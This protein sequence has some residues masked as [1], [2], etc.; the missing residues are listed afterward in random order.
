MNKTK[1]NTKKFLLEIGVEELPARHC[2]SI[3]K[4]LNDDLMKRLPKEHNLDFDNCE[5]LISPRRIVFLADN[6]TQLNQTQD[7]KG[8]IY[9]VAFEGDKP[10]KIA[11]KFAQSHGKTVDD[12][13]I[14]EQNDKRFLFVSKDLSDNFHVQIQNF[15]FEIINQLHFD[16]AMRWDDSKLEFSRPIRWIVCFLENEKIDLKLGNVKSSNI[17]KGNRF[18]Q[19][20]EIDISNSSNYLELI[21]DNF[22]MVDQ[23][24]RR[25]VIQ[26]ALNS[27]KEEGLKKEVSDTIE[28]LVSEVTYLIEWPVPILCQFEEEFLEIPKEIIV[29]VLSKHQKYFHLLNSNDDSLSNKFLVIANHKKASDKIRYGNEKVVKARLSD[30]AFFLEQD[31]DHDFEY[32]RKRSSTITFQEKLGSMLDKS[33]RLRE[34]APKIA[35]TLKSD[36]ESEIIDEAA[37]YSKADLATAMVTEFTSLEGTVGRIYSQKRDFDQKVSVALEEHYLPRNSTDKLP[38]SELGTILSLADKI[39]TLYGMFSLN[40]EPKGNSD[41]YGLRRAA[42]A[43]TKILWEKELEVGI[44]KLIEYPEDLFDQKAEKNTLK[45]FV[46]SRLEQMLQDQQALDDTNLLRAVVYNDSPLFVDKKAIITQLKRRKDSDEFEDLFEM[47]KRVYNIAIKGDKK[48]EEVEI[49]TDSLNKSENAFFEAIAELESQDTITLKDLLA[50][51]EPT[52]EFFENNM[53]MAKDTRKRNTR[54]N[55]LKK[56]YRL[57]EKL[58]NAEYLLS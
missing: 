9:D 13:E 47:I 21:R 4:Q 30:G 48:F 2:Q 34:I 24:E 3:L 36:I 37:K 11:H 44:D 40:L 7:I 52:N 50:L 20:P 43:I 18:D 27:L 14:R 38:G 42:I 32:F 35:N 1:E 54:L 25:E 12:I 26:E 55:M 28:N 10:N 41:P 39:D 45:E 8:P 57:I 23:T 33:Q 29:S 6:L 22:V 56:L 58:F 16:R 17:T 49:D 31:M 19:S 51:I 53:I 46:L 5:I 15:L